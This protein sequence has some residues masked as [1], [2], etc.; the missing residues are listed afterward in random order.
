MQTGLVDSKTKLSEKNNP[1]R[2]WQE[3][4]NHSAV[5]AKTGPGLAILLFANLSQIFMKEE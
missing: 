1:D 3:L 2:D 4:L 5:M